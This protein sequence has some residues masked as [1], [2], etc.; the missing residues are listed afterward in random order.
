VRDR[1]VELVVGD[2]RRS[3]GPGRCAAANGRL[4]GLFVGRARLGRTRSANRRAFP[5]R[6]RSRPRRTIDRFCLAARRATRVGYP[7]R[8]LSSRLARRD[9]ARTRG[10]AVLAL[11]SHPAYTIRGVR[12]GST[13]RSLRRQFRGE[14]RIRVGRNAWYLVRGSR[15][16]LVFRTARNRVREVGVAD[17]RL[18][19]T[20]AKAR[21]FLRSF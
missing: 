12:T 11:S 19:G 20:R 3:T 4:G 18:T 5:S 10:R 17:R 16:S 15:A 2:P 9:R 13:V 21:R 1:N 14:R 7:S 8:R 6:S